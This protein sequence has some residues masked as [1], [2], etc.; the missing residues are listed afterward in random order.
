MLRV[1]CKNTTKLFPKLSLFRTFARKFPSELRKSNLEKIIP[2]QKEPNKQNS[3]PSNQEK[4]D[5]PINLIKQYA[6]LKKSTDDIN[7]YDPLEKIKF[8]SDD[9]N[10]SNLY[11]IMPEKPTQKEE[12]KKD[13]LIVTPKKCTGCGAKLQ[14]EDKNSQGYI[15][16]KLFDEMQKNEIGGQIICQRCKQLKYHNKLENERQANIDILRKINPEKLLEKIFER[17]PKKALIVNIIDIIDF[18]GSFN[19]EIIKKACEKKCRLFIIINRMDLLPLGY[20]IQRITKWIIQNLSKYISRDQYDLCL[21]SSRNGEG[22]K[23]A[24]SIFKSIEKSLAKK[25]RKKP[26]IYVLGATNV[27]K[28][29]FLNKLIDKTNYHPGKA[30]ELKKKAE[31][32]LQIQESEKLPE[33]TSSR[34]PGTT[35]GFVKISKAHIGF[36]LHDTPGIP[37][38]N[39]LYTLLEDY[40]DMMSVIVTKRIKP[41]NIQLKAGNTV[42][43]GAL[44]QLD[45]LKNNAVTLSICVGEH[46]TIHKTIVEKSEKIYDKFAGNLLRPSISVDKNKIEWVKHDIIIT[47]K[48][49]EIAIQ[50]LGWIGIE[51]NGLCEIML[52]LPKGI[53]YTIRDALMPYEI[54]EKGLHKHSAITKNMNTKKNTV[55]REKY[56]ER[57]KAF[58][59]IS[60]IEAGESKKLIPNI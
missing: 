11:N 6:K 22:F 3:S 56:K 55:L 38:K 32:A 30:E 29:T 59:E 24:I 57:Q 39:Q 34:L 44:A 23:K 21:V 49:K 10:D 60:Q 41:Y 28:S 8:D 25:S 13:K 52:K 15:N 48:D 5:E 9:E 40:Q 37:N 31:Y 54:S 7:S 1:L 42:W 50:G 53:T 36:S 33:L 51:A 16:P 26:K 17:I 46:V 35:Q 47:E 12:S 43:L 45:I 27:G 2:L 18:E 4:D 14:K 19:P 58:E 20:K